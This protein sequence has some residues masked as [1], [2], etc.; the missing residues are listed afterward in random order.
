VELGRLWDGRARELAP[1]K[2]SPERRKEITRKTAKA[3]WD[4][5][6]RENLHRHRPPSPCF[7]LKGA[8][9]STVVW[10]D[11]DHSAVSV[12]VPSWKARVSADG[13]NDRRGSTLPQA[14]I[15]V[16]AGRSCEETPRGLVRHRTE[17]ADAPVLEGLQRGMATTLVRSSTGLEI[18][19]Q[20]LKIGQFQ[21]SRTVIVPS[22][23]S[24]L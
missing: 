16:V 13:P 19:D 2:L 3:P 7:F 8:I 22:I 9:R 6:R 21:P 14:V 11:I 10:A 18:F 5:K 17:R 23:P 1:K 20:R 15:T 12:P 24:S 4:K